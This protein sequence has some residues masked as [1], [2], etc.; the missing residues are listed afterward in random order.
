MKPC[1]NININGENEC[2][3]LINEASIES[4]MEGCYPRK[5]LFGGTALYTNDSLVEIY[6]ECLVK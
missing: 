6:H 3:E 1:H 2:T 4:Y 5:A